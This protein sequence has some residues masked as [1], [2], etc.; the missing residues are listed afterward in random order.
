MMSSAVVA[1]FGLLI[2]FPFLMAY[3]A[4][5]DLLTM[6]IP[7]RISLGLVFGFLLLAASGLMSWGE[8]GLHVGAAAI[9]LT[10]TFTLFAFN[11]IGGG[12]AKLAAAT[13][14]WLGFDGL[15]DYLL[16]ASVLGGILTLALLAARSHPLPN[17]LA[18]LPFALRLHDAKTGI[19]YGIALSA[20]ALLVMPETAVWTA[21]T[22]G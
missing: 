14:L 17:P 21:V 11:V 16:A 1:E 2:L 3:A 19:P 20:A 5:S 15:P 10:A 22:A 12:D 6:L 8:I 18:R 4:A 9:V 13:A 7:N